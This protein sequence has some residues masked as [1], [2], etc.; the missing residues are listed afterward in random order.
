L[1]APFASSQAADKFNDTQ[2]QEIDKMIRSYIMENP[3]V[4]LDAVQRMQSQAEEGKKDLAKKNLVASRDKLLNDPNSPTSG[5]LKGDVTIV[6]FFDY[7][8][9]YCKR[10]VPTL[11]KA[12][13]DDGNVRV[14]YKELPILGPK[15]VWELAPEKYEAFHT[16]LMANKGSFSEFKI[17]S[18]ASNLEIDGN[19]VIKSMKSDSIEADLGEN[20]A[21]AQS[22]G[23]SG[24]PAF[25]IGNELVPGAVDLETLKGL[26]KKARGS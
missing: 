13:K 4:I 15:S 14:V 12:V 11:M 21:L 6:E 20:H 5:N 24:T 16:A 7:R 22:L 18:I 3:Q 9:G 8:C 23:I 19:A 2:R 1:T 17:H 25:I 26:I 10:V